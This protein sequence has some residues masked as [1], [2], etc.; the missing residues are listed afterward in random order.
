PAATSPK[1][2]AADN[3]SIIELP[4]VNLESVLMKLPLP[5][6]I[7]CF[8]VSP[9][10][11]NLIKPDS[12]FAQILF[13]AS[14]SA[15]MIHSPLHLRFHLI[16]MNSDA[17][18]PFSELVEIKP[19]FNLTLDGFEVTH[20]CNGLVLL[21][22]HNMNDEIHRCAVCNPITGEY[23][24]LPDTTMLSRNV[25]CAFSYCPVT[26]RF[27]IFRGFHRVYRFGPDYDSDPDLD[28]DFDYNSDDSDSIYS[29]SDT[30]GEYL[31]LG[32]DD[33]EPLGTLPFCPRSMY[34]PCYLNNASHWLCGDE[35]VQVLIVSFNFVTGQFGEI[36]GPAHM[37]KAHASLPDK[38]NMVLHDGS[39]SIFDNHTRKTKFEVWM[40]KEHGVEGS[41]TRAFVIDIAAWGVYALQ[42]SFT[43]VVCRNNG[44]VVMV[45]EKG[46]ILFHDLVK[47]RG[48]V[49]FHPTL[50]RPSKAIA[51]IPSFMPLTYVTRDTNMVVRNVTPSFSDPDLN[52]CNYLSLLKLNHRMD[53][54]GFAVVI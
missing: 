44:E 28:F 22:N 35:H 45:C 38:V 53:G 37:T 20:S 48:R 7:S 54:P 5:S 31:P 34:S 25:R 43:P 49:I 15:L 12:N 52:P 36:P 23:I 26:S 16:D 10:L 11:F 18:P 14:E 8:G 17:N 41:W 4:E 40:M 27:N 47:K 29:E 9:S 24:M 30:V 1:T 46:Y 3:R 33:W 51:H 39:L 50:Q 42:F 21:E 19:S 13:E 32:S 2:T 6:L